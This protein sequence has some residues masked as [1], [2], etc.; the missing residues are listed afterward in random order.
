MTW[1]RPDS[2][3]YGVTTQSL[4]TSYY[5]AGNRFGVKVAPVGLAFAL[6]LQERPELALYA[7]DGHPTVRG[8][9]L[10]AC[11]FYATLFG[12]SPVGITYAPSGIPAQDRDFLQKVAAQSGPP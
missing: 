1:E 5:A 11:V 2:V 6:A 7:S 8:T 12:K 4:A 3:Q 10:A 9:Y